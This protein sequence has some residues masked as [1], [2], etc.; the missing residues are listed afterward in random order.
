MQNLRVDLHIHTAASDGTWTP[1]ELVKQVKSV[2]IEVFAISDHDAID[3][4]EETEALAKKEGLHFVPSVEI[5][6]SYQGQLFHILGYRSDIKNAA[7]LK[8]LKENQNRFDEANQ[9]AL[10]FL[11][12]QG[13]SVDFD[14]F[15][16][17]SYDKRRGGWRLLNFVIDSG[18]CSNIDEFFSKLFAGHHDRLFPKF[19]DP[20]EAIKVIQ[21][22]GGIPIF[23]HPGMS[24]K[25][26]SPAEQKAAIERLLESGVKGMECYSTYHKPDAIKCYLAI[27]KEKNLLITGG[28][29]CHGSLIPARKLG[30]PEVYIKDLNLGAVFT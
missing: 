16:K 6:S 8:F 21:K 23:A 18:I 2:G 13:H 3:N 1:L 5:S 7:L 26:L 9:H 12:E 30:H 28:S 20:E 10:N 17:Y 25:N 27:C 11:V 24:F 15:K 29:D 4:V 14:A 22:A 19:P